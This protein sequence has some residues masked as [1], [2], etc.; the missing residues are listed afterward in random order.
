MP[1]KY[2]PSFANAM[3]PES[4]RVSISTSQRR[5]R[6]LL[7][8]SDVIEPI[9]MHNAHYRQSVTSEKCSGSVRTGM[10]LLSSEPAICA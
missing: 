2:H 9:V 8:D 10:G 6:E 7:W 1:V 5:R 4:A 3:H